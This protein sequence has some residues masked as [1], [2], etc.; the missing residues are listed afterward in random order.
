LG[1]WYYG[2]STKDLRGLR[3]FQELEAPHIAFHE[4]VQKAVVAFQR[5]NNKDAQAFV[6]QAEQL[7]QTIISMLDAL[8]RKMKTS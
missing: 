7:S 5:G 3:E 6:H 4:N 2:N 8:E 1:A